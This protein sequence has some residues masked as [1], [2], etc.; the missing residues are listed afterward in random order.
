MVTVT[1]R[2]KK[3]ELREQNKNYL[4]HWSSEQSRAVQNEVNFLSSLTPEGLHAC[5]FLDTL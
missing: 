2:T 1:G 3:D 5:F 4:A